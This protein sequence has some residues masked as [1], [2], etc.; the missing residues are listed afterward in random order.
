MKPRRRPWR[1][2]R[3]LKSSSQELGRFPSAMA[4]GTNSL[5]RD[6]HRPT[7]AFARHFLGRVFNISSYKVLRGIFLDRAIPLMS[8]YSGVV[9][10][11]PRGPSTTLTLTGPNLVLISREIRLRMTL[12]T[13]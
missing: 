13:G 9:R 4:L 6:S 2:E 10:I 11:S 3:P 1:L 12:R 8:S 5:R 7:R